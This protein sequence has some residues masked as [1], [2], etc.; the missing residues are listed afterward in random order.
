MGTLQIDSEELRASR[1]ALL[2]F[3]ELERVQ[4]DLLNDRWKGIYRGRELT[5]TEIELATISL[6]VLYTTHKAAI[7]E[8][9]RLL[10][11]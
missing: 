10:D 3:L 9:E 6:Q 2:H 4:T 1:V 8:L 5:P 7:K 11:K